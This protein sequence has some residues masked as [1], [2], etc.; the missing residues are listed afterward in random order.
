VKSTFGYR[1]GVACLCLCLL[2][3]VGRV[4]WT[5]WSEY[6][7]GLELE[8]QE[9]WHEAAVRHGRAIHMY[10][11]GSPLAAKA[12]DRLLALAQAAEDRGEPREARFC[13][14]ELR[15]GFLSIRSFYQPGAS[16]VR[17]AE[18]GLT[19]LMLQDPRG[20]WPARDKTTQQREAE[21]RTVFAER[22]DPQLFWVLLMGLGYFLWLGAAA[23][24]IWRGLPISDEAA[25]DWSSLKRWSA[26]SALGYLTWLLAIWQA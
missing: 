23:R 15:S 17:A 4:G 19:P 12:G 14:E 7:E 1:Q 21:I 11:P 5:G 24:A 22:E 9:L 18:D 26:A 10:L 3:V 2:V 20:N 13:Y 16:Y 8:S 25:V 6:S